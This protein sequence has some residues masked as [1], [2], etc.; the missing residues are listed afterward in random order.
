MNRLLADRG[1]EELR[2]SSLLRNLPF[3]KGSF[4]LVGLVDAGK[5]ASPAHLEQPDRADYSGW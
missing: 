5:Y 4:S 1:R 2:V 3:L